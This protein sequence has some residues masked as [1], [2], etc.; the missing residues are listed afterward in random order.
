MNAV[1]H[2]L[3]ARTLILPGEDPEEFAQRLAAW[4]ADLQPCNPFEEDLVRQAVGHSWRLER[5]DWLQ[6]EILSERIAAVPLDEARRRREEVADLG[7]RLLPGPPD[8]RGDHAAR[9][10][11]NRRAGPDDPDD[12]ARLL[13]RLEATADGCRWLLDRWAEKRRSPEAGRAWSPAEMVE[14]IRLLGKRPLEDLDDRRVLSVVLACFALDRQRPDPFA[15]L[16]EGLTDCEVQRCR[17]WLLERG[18]AASMPCTPEEARAV[19]LEVVDDADAELRSLERHHRQREEA[20]AAIQADLLSFD[21][22]REGESLRRH[23]IRATRAIVRISER[24]REAR[25]R[26]RAGAGPPR[27]ARRPAGGRR[28]RQSG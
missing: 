23:Q 18:L 4:T 20:R 7:R 13:S 21:E 22:S 2:G 27:A 6:V 12:P 14:A 16:W 5:A 15:A 28:V 19:L 17:E 26:G 3:T 11:S 8:P 1:T 10:E 9:P 24:F 25:Q